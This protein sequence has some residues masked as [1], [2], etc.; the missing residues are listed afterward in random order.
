MGNAL[1]S[2]MKYNESEKAYLDAIA[3]DA[4]LVAAHSNLANLLAFNGM[5]MVTFSVVDSE[6]DNAKITLGRW[7][8]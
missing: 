7:K 3:L 6:F 1:A 5:M 4:K 2:V 8:Y